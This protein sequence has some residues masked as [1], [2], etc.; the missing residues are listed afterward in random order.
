LLVCFLVLQKIEFEEP[1]CGVLGQMVS[2]FQTQKIIYLLQKFYQKQ[3]SGFGK[4]KFVFHNFSGPRFFP[5]A[6]QQRCLRFR[7][8]FVVGQK[9]G[10]LG[11]CLKLRVLTSISINQTFRCS[12]TI[13]TSTQLLSKTTINVK[14]VGPKKCQ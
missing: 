4:S 14:R 11:F 6:K 10:C 1:D 13:W 5:V 12:M 3:N 8:L 7:A 9:F 2:K